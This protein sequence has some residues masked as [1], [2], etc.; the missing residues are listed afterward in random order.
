M[1]T[2]NGQVD[3]VPPI[4]ADPA[5]ETRQ[6]ARKPAESAAAHASQRRT[7]RGAVLITG[8]S[9]GIGRATALRLDRAGYEVFAT[10]RQSED[11]VQLKSQASS[12][13]RT[14]ILDITNP[15]E[16]EAALDAVRETLGPRHGLHALVNNAGTC[17]PG[18]I[19]CIG[20]ERFRRQMEV[21]VIG[22][23]QVIQAFLPL[24]RLGHGRIVNVASAAAKA[25]LPLF[26]AYAASKCAM[27]GMSDALRRELRWFGIPVS[28]VEPGTVE[29]AIWDKTPDSPELVPGEADNPA[30]ALYDAMQDGVHALMQRGRRAAVPPE[31]LAAVIQRAIE[32]RWPRARYRHGPGARMSVLANLLPEFV[33]DWFIEKIIKKKLPT[34]L[35]GW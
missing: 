31:Q 23:V 27:E 11:A 28:I 17:E 13:L 5:R 6:P 25:P 12:R 15:K 32:A 29:A 2:P 20:I 3:T 10:V 34:R 4:D 30:N 33:T 16:I 26:G 21:N 18:A 22:H 14:L 19:E 35:M 7:D 24:V 8:T 1:T 9:S